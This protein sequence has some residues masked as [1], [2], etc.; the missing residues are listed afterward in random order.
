MRYYIII[1]LIINFDQLIFSQ[2]IGANGVKSDSRINDLFEDLKNKVGKQNTKNFRIKGSPYFNLSF[3]LAQIEYFGKDL[4]EKIYLRYNALNDEMEMSLNLLST[5]SENIL[6]K[7]N[8]VSCVINNEKYKYLKFY[9]ENSNPIVGYLSVL[10]KGDILTL[11]ERKQKIYLEAT[12][13]RT[14]LE[15]SFP[16]RYSD[17]IEYYFSIN[18]GSIFEIKLNKKDLFRKLKSY[19]EGIKEYLSLNKIKIRSKEDLL[20]LFSHLDTI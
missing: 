8:K 2:S 14:S 18:N 1:L 10:F 15:R 4:N 20:S 19:S 12:K 6:M 13:A 7:S 16:A 9:P 11:Y 5:N 17:K 3:E